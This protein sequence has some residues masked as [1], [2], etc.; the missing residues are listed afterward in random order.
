MK[1]PQPGI[2]LLLKRAVRMYSVQE[3]AH[4]SEMTDVD[5]EHSGM[6]MM[7]RPGKH[8]LNVHFKQHRF[9]NLDLCNVK[10]VGQM[11]FVLLMNLIYQSHSI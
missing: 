2:H 3:V 9:W 8:H 11:E 4:I 1:I 5:E 6:Q 7:F 10:L